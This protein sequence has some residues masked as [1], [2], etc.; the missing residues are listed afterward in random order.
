MVNKL[1]GHRGGKAGNTVY[2]AEPFNITD[3]INALI[4]ESNPLSSPMNSVSAFCAEPTMPSTAAQELDEDAWGNWGGVLSKRLISTLG[5]IPEEPRALGTALATWLELE[6]WDFELNHSDDVDGEPA[7]E[8]KVSACP[9]WDI[10]LRSN[11]KDAVDCSVVDSSFLDGFARRFS[12]RWRVE[13]LCTRYLGND[14]CV[15]RFYIE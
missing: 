8:L 4:C 12:P 2:L 9:W 15:F 5:L 13:P 14:A 10:L 6:G 3:K 1:R 11:R 7:Y